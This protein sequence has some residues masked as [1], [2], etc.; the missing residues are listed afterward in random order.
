MVRGLDELWRRRII[1]EQSGGV[2]GATYDFSHDKIRQVAYVGVSPARRRLLHLRI[3]SV[4]ERADPSDGEPMS[5]PDRRALRP[6][7]GAAE[8]GRRVVPARG[9]GRTAVVRQRSCR[10]ARRT[11]RALGLLR[12]MPPST[13]RDAVELE[14]H[15]ALL[16]PLISMT[17]YLSPASFPRPSSGGPANWRGPPGADPG[18]PLLRSLALSAMT[19]GAFRETTRFGQLRAAGE[20]DAD[21][22][23]VV[24][25][26]YLLGIAGVLGS[27]L[28]GAPQ[29]PRAGRRALSAADSPGPTCFTTAR[30]LRWSASLAGPARCGSSARPPPRHTARA[31]ALAWA[32]GATTRSRRGSR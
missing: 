2:V 11:E 12:S 26:A 17:G 6:G 22:V 9:G 31:A 18:P 30:T 4:L 1:R 3:A 8:A 13:K 32:E 15:T 28:P 16:V 29:P 27:R 21:D 25:A 20:R 24:E 7:A 14:V 23:L 19:S 5:L 10:R